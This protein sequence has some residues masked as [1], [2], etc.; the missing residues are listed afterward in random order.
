MKNSEFFSANGISQVTSCEV[1]EKG[2]IWYLTASSAKRDFE[3]SNI[4]YRNVTVR[5]KDLPV[6]YIPYLRMP[7]P[8]VDRAQ[9]FLVPEAVLTS[10]LATGLKLP[11]FVPTGISSDILITP[12][13][14]S[15]TN[16]IE[17]RYR[18]KFRKGD[19]TIK[20]AISD[21]DLMVNNLRYFSQLTGHFELGYGIDLNLNV[22]KVGDTSYLGDYVYSEESDFNSEISLGKTIVEKQ[23]FF[24][25][26]LTYLR[27]KEKG[28][29]LDEYYAFSGTYLKSI[30]PHI[31]PGKLRYSANLN[32][33][34]NIINDNSISRP[35][36]SAQVGLNYKQINTLGQME[37]STGVF[38]NLNS[39]VNSA[40]A[41]TT[42]EE[43]SVQYGI[44]TLISV[45]YFQ[46]SKGKYAF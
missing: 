30:D 42:N 12:Y 44:S 18:K 35:P 33:S 21:D 40:D 2:P 36:S 9:G 7:D 41:G 34:F 37:F 31:L 6:A 27:E 45:P 23:Q 26:N 1:C 19:L 17:Y 10:N 3:N 11:Y 29:S 14:S 16:T 32:S 22:G 39:F 13:L 46:Q 15:K 5:F 28:N 25:G 38:G 24:D 20:G 43:F 4:V 8:S